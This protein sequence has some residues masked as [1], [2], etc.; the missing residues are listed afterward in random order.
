MLWKY[1]SEWMLIREGLEIP[2][3]KCDRNSQ[4]WETQFQFC[5][6]L[7][8]PSTVDNVHQ[9]DGC[10]SKRH[11]VAPQTLAEL[12]WLA[13]KLLQL[14]FILKEKQTKS[15]KGGTQECNHFFTDYFTARSHSSYLGSIWLLE[16]HV[17][18]CT[19][20]NVTLLQYFLQLETNT[21]TRSPYRHHTHS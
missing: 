11:S 19:L 6:P 14:L 17:R 9:M 12:L 4:T 2:R 10:P 7:K 8:T 1:K 13:A 21:H 15:L 18:L 5:V 16:D 3:E 20:S